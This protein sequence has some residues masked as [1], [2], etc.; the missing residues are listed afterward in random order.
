VRTELSIPSALDGIILACLEKDPD[1][2]PPNADDLAARLAACP[3]ENPW[4]AARARSWWDVH[5]PAP[6]AGDPAT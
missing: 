5:H 3:L 2:R 4:T 1:R 6:R